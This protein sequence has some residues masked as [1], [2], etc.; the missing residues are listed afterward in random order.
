MTTPLAGFWSYVRED[1]EAEGDRITQL[2]RLIKDEYELQTADEIHLFI[3]TDEI[4]WGD[5]WRQVIEENLGAVAFFIPVMTPRYLLSSE[6][7][8]ELEFFARRARKGGF[9]E[10]LLPLHY[11]NVSSLNPTWVKMNTETRWQR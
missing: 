7:R 5:A 10:L 11:T 3:D 2:A 9:S 1:D 4:Q 6:C 8:R